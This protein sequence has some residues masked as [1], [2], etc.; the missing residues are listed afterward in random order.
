MAT[1]CQSTPEA[2]GW[3]GRYCLRWSEELHNGQT[4]SEY[5]NTCDGAHEQIELYREG[6]RLRMS[7]AEGRRPLQ[8]RDAWAADAEGLLDACGDSVVVAYR[9][10]RQGEQILLEKAWSHEGEQMLIRRSYTR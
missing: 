3:E 5:L 4:V 9:L 6:H 8:E 7:G 2:S 10:R 1:G